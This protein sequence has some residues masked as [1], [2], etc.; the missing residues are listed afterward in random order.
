MDWRLLE[1]AD[2]LVKRVALKLN[3]ILTIDAVK[4][5]DWDD[6]FGLWATVVAPWDVPIEIEGRVR[7]VKEGTVLYRGQ[8][9][10]A[11]DLERLTAGKTGVDVAKD[12]ELEAKWQ[13]LRDAMSHILRRKEL[14]DVLE[15]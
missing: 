11:E 8:V 3:D 10:D 15:G 5:D 4:L 7:K 1:Q 14:D 12:L 2:P 13:A 9:F 6:Y